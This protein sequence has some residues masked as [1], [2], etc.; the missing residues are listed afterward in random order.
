MKVVIQRVKSS[1][2]TVNGKIIG[3]IKRGLNVLFAFTQGD[4]DE[5]LE[6]M[7]EKILN[8]RIFE[9]E[10]GKMNKSLLDINGELLLISQFTLYGDCSKGRRP[11]FMRALSKDEA[12]MLYD[13]FIRLLR[14]EVK[15]VKSGQF[16][17]D[18]NVKIEND[19]PV[20]LIIDSKKT[21]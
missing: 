21:S 10:N 6:Y 17:A 3:E 2:V 4:S 9:D 15:K 12:K 16:G 11:N 14:G 20:T 5:D 1:S 18:M 19:G 8:L 7:K 13:K